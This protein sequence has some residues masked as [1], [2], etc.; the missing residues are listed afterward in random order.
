MKV[1]L[2]CGQSF[3]QVSWLC[4]QCGHCPARIGK[5]LS[6]APE[7]SESNEGFPAD[8]HERLFQLESEHFWFRARNKL[9]LWALAKYFPGAKSFLEIGCGN[10]FV[11]SGIRAEHAQMELSGSEIYGRTLRFAAKRVPDAELYQIDA[12]RIPFRDHFDVIGAFDVLEHIRDDR[13]VLKE[14]RKVVKKEGGG[15]ILTVPQHAFLWSVVDEFSC[16]F[17]RYSAKELRIKAEQAR[18]RVLAM[19]SF[20]SFLLPLMFAVRW[21]NRKQS[22]NTFDRESE[23]RLSGPI[24]KMLEAILSVERATV[25]GGMRWPAGGSLL[26]VARPE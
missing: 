22:L 7:L 18:F 3:Q 6:F 5:Y 10:G 14:M 25:A 1:C 12:T 20:M 8:S 23:F 13:L 11:L 21:K 16:H 24:N 17:R 9:I 15:I 4:P 2:T 19:T 26:L